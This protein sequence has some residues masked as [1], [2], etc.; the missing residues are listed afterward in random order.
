VLFPSIFH[1]H[2]SYLK[3]T[4]RRLFPLLKAIVCCFPLSFIYISCVMSPSILYWNQ[5]CAVCFLYWKQLCAV[6]L[7]PL[8]KSVVC[9]FLLILFGVSCLVFCNIIIVRIFWHTKKYWLT[10]LNKRSR[11][12][13]LSSW[14]WTWH[15]LTEQSALFIVS[16][17]SYT[18]VF[19]NEYCTSSILSTNGLNSADVPL[20]NKQTSY[21]YVAM[22]FLLLTLAS[23]H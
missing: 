7:Y 1:L 21:H 13:G 2:Q 5:F 4:S 20:S 10:D 23:H 18:V 6:S 15:W 3:I 11:A 16:V 17:S 9:C 8:L 14:M 22:L 12:S 19:I